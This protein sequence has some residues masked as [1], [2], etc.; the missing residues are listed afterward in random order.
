VTNKMQSVAVLKHVG[1]IGHKACNLGLFINIPT[2][3]YTMQF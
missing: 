2:T 1:A 3:I